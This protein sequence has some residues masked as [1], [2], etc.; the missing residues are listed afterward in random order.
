MLADHEYAL[1]DDILILLIVI[2]AGIY[3]VHVA[4]TFGVEINGL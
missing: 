2:N 4:V 1:K 3:V